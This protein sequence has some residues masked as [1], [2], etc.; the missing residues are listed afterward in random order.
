M[1]CS[2]PLLILENYLYLDFNN[3]YMYSSLQLMNH[4]KYRAS[5]NSSHDFSCVTCKNCLTA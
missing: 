2:G 5:A 1:G 3:I 4:F